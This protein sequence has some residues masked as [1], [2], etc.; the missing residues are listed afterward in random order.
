VQL[1]CGKQIHFTERLDLSLKLNPDKTRGMS[2]RAGN[3]ALLILISIEPIALEGD[4][5]KKE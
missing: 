4:E 2:W 5:L 1:N 3:G